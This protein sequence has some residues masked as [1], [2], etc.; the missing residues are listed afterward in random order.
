MA[1]RRRAFASEVL[2]F[3]RDDV[4]AVAQQWQF[5]T[6]SFA[7]SLGDDPPAA[8][9]RILGA[10]IATNGELRDRLQSML[11]QSNDLAEP[12]RFSDTSST[13]V[14]FWLVGLENAWLGRYEE[15]VTSSNYGIDSLVA[16]VDPDADSAVKAR[17]ALAME[18][19]TVLPGPL[20][21][22]VLD[23]APGGGRELVSKAIG[24]LDDLIAALVQANDVLSASL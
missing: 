21:A 6:Q 17:L 11:D 20:D 7:S 18:A 1:E 15:V 22:G 13:D 12:S 2:A 23:A 24:A 3:L 16:K 14:Y 4:R 10:M 8:L 5:T 19:L 9:P